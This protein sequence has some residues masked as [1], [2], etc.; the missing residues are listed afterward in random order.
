MAIEFFFVRRDMIAEVIVD[1]LASEVDKVFD[2]KIP[3]SFA[4]LTIGYR[5]LVPF[6]NRRIEGFVMAIKEESDLPSEKVK[7]ILEVLDDYPV[8]LPEVID[9]IYFMKDKLYLRLIDGIRLAVPSQVRNGTKEKFDKYLILKEELI[10]SDV[11]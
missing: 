5:V 6:G 9:L 1:V 3:S 8:L 10:K 4:D 7:E 11:V 2:Y